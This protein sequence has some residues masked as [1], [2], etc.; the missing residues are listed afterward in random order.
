M[1]ASVA[2]A[3]TFAVTGRRLLFTSRYLSSS[4]FR[5]YDAAPDG[6]HFVMIRGNTAQSTLVALHNVFERLEYDRQKR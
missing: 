6:Q 5:E 2:L 1:V 3:P 4:T